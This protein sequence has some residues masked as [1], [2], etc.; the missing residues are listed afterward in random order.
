V[1]AR[2]PPDIAA[3]ARASQAKWRIPASVSLAQWA[4]ESGWGAK[5]PGN[6]PFGMKPRTGK[7]DPFQMLMT[8]E[9]SKAR[10]NVMVPQPFRT[11]PS[12][13]AA[14]DA[15]AELLATAP[16]YARA[17]AVLPDPDKFVEQLQPVLDARG[18][19]VKPGY[20]TD[21]NYAATLKAVMRGSA[22]LYAYN[23]NAEAR[24]A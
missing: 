10:G 12:I 9:W 1:T 16:V 6:N 21:P 3:A 20:A 17:R 18:R 11:F 13:A 4:V 5:S 15:H 22:K 8:R 24:R 7:N 14:F 23:D 2:V 19:V